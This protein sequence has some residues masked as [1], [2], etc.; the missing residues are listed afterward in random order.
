[1]RT[2]VGAGAGFAAGWGFLLTVNGFSSY[3]VPGAGRT[4]CGEPLAMFGLGLLVSL[5]VAGVLVAAG[6]RVARQ[7][8]G[9]T[10]VG[11]GTSLWLV[12]LVTVVLVR[13]FVPMDLYQDEVHRLMTSAC[14]VTAC[15]SYAL[16]A[17]CTGSRPSGRRDL[18][19]RRGRWLPWQA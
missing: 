14:L 2:V 8:R 13:L 15:V 17:L 11:I 1:M 3:C 6:F 7:R 12:L 4:G 9:W 19:P 5:V 10:V 18:G 16:A